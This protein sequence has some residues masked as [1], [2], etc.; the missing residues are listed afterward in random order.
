MNPLLRNIKEDDLNRAIEI[1][2]A[3][4]AALKLR[5]LGQTWTTSTS[6]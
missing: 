2:E 4:A 1:A 5:K 3:N 6:F